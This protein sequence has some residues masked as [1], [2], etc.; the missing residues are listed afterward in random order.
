VFGIFYAIGQ[1]LPFPEGQPYRRSWRFALAMGRALHSST[2][3]INL[4]RF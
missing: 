4:S 1:G 3:Q 2:V